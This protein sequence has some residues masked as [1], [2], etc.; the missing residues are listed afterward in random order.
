MWISNV[1]VTTSSPVMSR[2][3][4]AVVVGAGPAGLSAAAEMTSAGARCLV[5]EQ[6][7]VHTARDRDAPEDVLAGVGGAGLFSDGKHSFFPAATEL[8]R[9]PD[10]ELLARAFEETRALLG[11]H[12]VAAPAFSTDERA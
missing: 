7:P 2:P 10:R 4:D 12:G 1:P 9:L 8:W 5:I 6:G 3:Y 11:R